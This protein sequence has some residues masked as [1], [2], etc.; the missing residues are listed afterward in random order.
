[1]IRF[2]YYLRARFRAWNYKRKYGIS[3]EEAML[4][5]GRNILINEQKTD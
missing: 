3:I 1:M 2:F 5:Y 4:W